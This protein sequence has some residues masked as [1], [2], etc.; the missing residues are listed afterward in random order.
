ML[1]ANSFST[2]KIVRTAN[3]GTLITPNAGKIAGQ[4][5]CS[6]IAN[7]MNDTTT[8]ITKHILTV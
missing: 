5:K 8:Y 6:F 2:C 7:G 4:W 1:C 3:S